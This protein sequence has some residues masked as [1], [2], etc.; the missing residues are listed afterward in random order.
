MAFDKEKVQTE[1]IRVEEE[2]KVKLATAITQ[3]YLKRRA[4]RRSVENG[5]Q[6]N[7][8]FVSGNQYCDVSPF[9]EVLEED[10]QFYW[11]SRRVFNHIAPLIDARIAKILQRKPAL[12]VKAFSD[13]D[14]DRKAAAVAT[15]ILRYVDEKIRID[16]LLARG[17]VW[18]ET[19]GV[20]FYK[21][22]WNADGGRQVAIDEFG[23]PVYEG[24]VDVT[25]VPPFEIFPD[26]LNVE[27][28]DEL[29]SLIHA[30]AV[31]V[32]YVFEKFGVRVVATD[33]SDSGVSAYSES[34]GGKVPVKMGMSVAPEFEV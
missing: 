32:D 28:M 7:M 14:G 5:W 8:N 11:Q 33:L 24:E 22:V 9:G 30:Q 12:S 13:E 1:K 25:V 23:N 29:D 21:A 31:S 3:D 15:G 16:D 34:C 18:A 20:V 27:C 19:C 26:R 17:T 6:L 10:K 2:R 4:D